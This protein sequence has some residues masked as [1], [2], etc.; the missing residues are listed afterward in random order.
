MISFIIIIIIFRSNQLSISHEIITSLHL[1]RLRW[2]K[3]PQGRVTMQLGIEKH[4]NLFK[5]LFD[6]LN[7][8]DVSS[9]FSPGFL[10]RIGKKPLL[11]PCVFSVDFFYK[12]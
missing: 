10:I 5:Y 2:V 9:I 11:R 8:L 12:F 6:M 4:E 3:S 7:F 1:T